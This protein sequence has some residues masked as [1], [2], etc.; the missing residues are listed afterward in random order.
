MSGPRQ[1][2]G[3]AGFSELKPV[4]IIRPVEESEPV[5]GVRSLMARLHREQVVRKEFKS[6]YLETLLQRETRLV[7]FLG[8]AAIDNY[9]NVLKL[10]GPKAGWDEPLTVPVDDITLNDRKGGKGNRI[11]MRLQTGGQ[12][13]KERDWALQITRRL[14]GQ[15]TPQT[16]FKRNITLGMLNLPYDSRRLQAML[17]EVKPDEINLLPTVVAYSPYSRIR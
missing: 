6:Y 1:E 8:Q 15:D 5:I 16:F 12:L 11:V 4:H 10:L 7:S 13:E 17:S 14:A 2:S 9:L 3:P